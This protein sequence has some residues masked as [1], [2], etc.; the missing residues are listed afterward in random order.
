MDMFKFSAKSSERFL[1]CGR[2]LKQKGVEDAIYATKK[3]RGELDIVGRHYSK[4][5]LKTIKAICT[6]K[7]VYRGNKNRSD[8]PKLYR[9]AKAL[10]F[11]IKWE[12]PFGLVM[13]EAM[14]SGTPVI[15]YNRGSV[16]EVIKDGVTGFIV[17]NKSEMIRAM[18]KIDTIDRN[19]CRR[20][21]EKRFSTQRMVNDYEK[22]YYKASKWK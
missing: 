19:E 18:K 10:L 2:L 16:P 22:L 5:Y 1:F 17:K 3:C 11:P 12:E 9:Q 7:V 13:I 14:A 6:K 15:A 8:L 20:W 21:V 4:L